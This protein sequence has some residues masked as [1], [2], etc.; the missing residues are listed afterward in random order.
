MKQP[1]GTFVWRDNSGHKPHARHAVEDIGHSAAG[2]PFSTLSMPANFGR[3][4]AARKTKD[5]LL[6]SEAVYA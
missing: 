4:S 2:G 3:S 5:H 1:D 6:L